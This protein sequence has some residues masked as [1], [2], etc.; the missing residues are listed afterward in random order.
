MRGVVI[1][2]AVMALTATTQAGAR[3]EAAPDITGAWTLNRDLTTTPERSREGRSGDRGRPPGGGMGGPGGIGGR[4]GFGG[5]GGGGGRGGMGGSRGP[6]DEER[7][8]M[9]V[10]R[11]RMT[12]IPDRLVITRD[13]SRVSITDG[14]GHQTTLVADGKKQPRL[15]GDGDFK[16]VTHFE[17]AQLVVQ[18]D[19]GGAKVI[20]TYTPS[21]DEAGHPRLEVK[22]HASRGGH[23]DGRDGGHGGPPEATRVYEAELR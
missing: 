19:F 21:Q 6:G 1:G 23:G 8:Q 11:R 7:R 14:E 9:E 5:M 12:E 4:G 2:L 10:V 22:V 18:E 15:T 20:T 16:S 13:G 17:G 3:R